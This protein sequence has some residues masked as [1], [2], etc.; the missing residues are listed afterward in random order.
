MR[1][2]GIGVWCWSV[3]A[4]MACGAWSAPAEAGGYYRKGTFAIG[5]G[6]NNP[7]GPGDQYFNG[8]GTFNMMGGRNVN[9]HFTLQAEYTHNW[10]DIDQSVIDKAESDSVQFDN[11]H[12]SLWSVTLNGVYRFK[13]QSD[14]VP[15]V[16][17]GFGYYKR[18]LQITQDALVYYPPYWDPWWG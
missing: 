18:N 8:S 2:R 7:V 14:I 13:P 11:T 1:I 3:L 5:G 12:S 15:W 9:S 10:L 17:G 4:V 16:T 6:F